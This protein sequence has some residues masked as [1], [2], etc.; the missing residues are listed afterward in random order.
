M[1]QAD[2]PVEGEFVS[3]SPEETIG[4]GETIARWLKPGSI[5]ALSGNLGAGKTLLSKG[6]ARGL[7]VAEEI[8]SPTYTIISEYE[9]KYPLYHIDAYRLSGDEEFAA[10]GAEELLYGR[11]ICLIEWAD[12]LSILPGGTISV[13]IAIIEEGKRRICYKKGN[14]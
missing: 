9:G 10:A 13:T 4:F 11:G 5:V 1:K 14:G 2:Y 12:R 7:G 3:S 6:I 8:T